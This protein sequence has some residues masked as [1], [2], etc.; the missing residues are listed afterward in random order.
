MNLAKIS[1]FQRTIFIRRRGAYQIEGERYLR[2]LNLRVDCI[3]KIEDVETYEF[4]VFTKRLIFVFRQYI[5][6]V[7]KR[8]FTWYSFVSR[9][10]P[11]YKSNPL[12]SK[13]MYKF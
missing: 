9:R 4:R 3:V 12:G 7:S 2:S 1:H 6:M 5:Y 13:T 11:D 10:G 8:I